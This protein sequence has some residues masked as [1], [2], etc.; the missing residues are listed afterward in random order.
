MTK[1]TNKQGMTPAEAEKRFKEI[2]PERYEFVKL[3]GCF[4]YTATGQPIEWISKQEF[5]ETEKETML[6][7]KREHRKRLK[8]R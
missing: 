6:R 8:K 7:R 3:F 4:G 2:N 5:M 1:K